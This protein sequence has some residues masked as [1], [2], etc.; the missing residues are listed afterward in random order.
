MSHNKGKHYTV[1]PECKRK[2]Y[3]ITI[4]DKHPDWRKTT[5]SQ[6]HT[7]EWKIGKIEQ[8]LKI[9][10]ERLSKVLP[11]LFERDDMFYANLRKK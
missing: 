3:C 8:I 2:R 4:K 1:C 10:M 7:W 9:E 11:N 6:G 5:C